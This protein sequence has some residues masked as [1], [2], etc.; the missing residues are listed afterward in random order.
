MKTK[1]LKNK[2]CLRKE[3]IS[4]LKFNNMN[5][6]ERSGHPCWIEISL[7]GVGITCLATLIPGCSK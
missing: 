6:N 1:D 4:S 3:N 5:G 2:L 7:L